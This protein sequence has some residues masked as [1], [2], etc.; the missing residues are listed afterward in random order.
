MSVRP[1][2][3]SADPSWRSSAGCSEA[4]TTTL[5]NVKEELP[6]SD[7]VPDEPA[8]EGNGME[9][10]DRLP[11]RPAFDD[12]TT[13]GPACSSPHSGLPGL[14]LQQLPCQ[15]KEESLDSDTQSSSSE[16]P[17]V[18]TEGAGHL[19]EAQQ[20][21]RT[22]MLLSQAPNDAAQQM[23]TSTSSDTSTDE[24]NEEHNLLVP[25]QQGSSDIEGADLLQCRKHDMDL[26]ILA[27][28]PSRDCHQ[29][30]GGCGLQIT[31][32]GVFTCQ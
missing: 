24:H 3:D 14:L 15:V 4:P 29:S 7:Q 12:T 2:Q 31:T 8:G 21:M 28:L 18:M 6:I 1:G 5:H 27:Y 19:P 10:T 20:P 26:R 17:P 25:A 16:V 13:T 9:A 32:F 23:K 11:S 30:A 22:A